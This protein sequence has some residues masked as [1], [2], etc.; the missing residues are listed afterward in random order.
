MITAR[1]LEMELEKRRSL[2]A[3][4]YSFIVD[5]VHDVAEQD[6]ITQL[7]EAVAD[8]QAATADEEARTRAQLEREQGLPPGVRPAPPTATQSR[9]PPDA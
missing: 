2:T 5:W 9:P 4:E 3:Q 8:L 1:R 6:V 7:T